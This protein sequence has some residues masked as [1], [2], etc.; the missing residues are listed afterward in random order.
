MATEVRI[1]GT[2]ANDATVGT[3][4]WTSVSNAAAQDT[5]YANVVLNIA[6]QQSNYIKATN[7]SHLSGSTLSSSDIITAIQWDIIH[8]KTGNPAA[9]IKDFH[10]YP[11]ES[12]SINTAIDYADTVNLWSTSDETFSYIQ[13]SG[14]PTAATVLASNWGF[15][16][17]CQNVNATTGAQG[18]VD[19]IVAT[20]TF[21]QVSAAVTGTMTVDPIREPAIVAG[22]KTII[23][24]LTG[25][26]WVAA[27]AAF[28]AQR[29]NII[30]G[31]D[32]AGAEANGWDAKVK[33]LEVVGAVV[34]TSNTVVTI[35]LTAE[36]AY[37]IT[38]TE[39]ITATIP[40]T[41]VA[42]G[43]AIVAT[44]TFRVVPDISRTPGL[45]GLGIGKEPPPRAMAGT[46]RA[47][48]VPMWWSDIRPR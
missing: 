19:Y 20:I 28:D 25:D 44:P 1:F 30:N 3:I 46:P 10:A 33:G 27:G 29:Q 21:T 34:R 5:T 15:V 13:S 23:L 43:N 35:T 26:T 7:S 24:T 9:T 22:G 39:V 6:S 45:G 38:A 42:G 11:V 47:G 40:G 31:L 18:N 37:N 32:S 48:I 2:F 41:A 16:L 36:A 17:A 4:T 14:L 8:K 12:G